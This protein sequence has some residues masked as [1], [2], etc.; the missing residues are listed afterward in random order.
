[1]LSKKLI[2]EF[3]QIMKEEYGVEL[4][5]LEAHKAATNLVGYFDLLLKLDYENKS[6]LKKIKEQ[7]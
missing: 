5:D 7:K 1:M 4:S 2:D 3:K 6:K